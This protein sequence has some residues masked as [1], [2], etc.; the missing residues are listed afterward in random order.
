VNRQRDPEVPL[1]MAGVSMG[2]MVSV[3]TVRK[4]PS[5]WAVSIFKSLIELLALI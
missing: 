3:L 2:G 5:I 4:V 1:I